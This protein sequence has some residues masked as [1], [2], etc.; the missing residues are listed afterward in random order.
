M[1]PLLNVRECELLEMFITVKYFIITHIFVAL[2]GNDLVSTNGN[3]VKY[4]MQTYIIISM[5]VRIMGH[6]V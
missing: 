2:S 5:N 6:I 1:Y 4:Y 3:Q